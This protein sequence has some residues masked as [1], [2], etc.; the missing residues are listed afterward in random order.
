MNAVFKLADWFAS[1][2]AGYMMPGV[3]APFA[4]NPSA[5]ESDNFQ[6]RPRASCQEGRKR[7]FQKNAAVLWGGARPELSSRQPCNRD[8]WR[9]V[10]FWANVTVQ[11]PSS[12]IL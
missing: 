9:S 12:K 1:Q 5:E 6:A 11:A 2:T 8:W 7:S 4:R 10:H 3:D